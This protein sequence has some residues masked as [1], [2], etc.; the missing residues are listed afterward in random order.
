MKPKQIA[1]CETTSTVVEWL[2]AKGN[3]SCNWRQLICIGASDEI[4][5]ISAVIEKTDDKMYFASV[6]ADDTTEFDRENVKRTVILHCTDKKYPNPEA[7]L[8]GATA[9]LKAGS[10]TYHDIILK[11]ITPQDLSDDEITKIHKKGGITFVTKA[12]DNVTSV[13]I[14]LGGE[15]IDIVDSED[16][17]IQQITYRVQ[18]QL[19]Q[20][21]KIVHKQKKHIQ[22]AV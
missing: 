2:K 11:G 12:G 1:I 5:A 10:F 7:A 9:G 16:Y 14:T 4:A 21:L 20:Y 13:G 8:V 19:K 18:K 15:Y 6:P 3:L 17:V 22:S